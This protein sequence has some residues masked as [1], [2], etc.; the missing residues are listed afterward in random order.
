MKRPLAIFLVTLLAYG[1]TASGH[2]YSPD[3]ELYFR[4]TRSLALGQGLAIE[5]LGGFATRRPAPPRADGKE[6]AQYGIGQPLLAIPFY[7]AG[8]ALGQLG[9]D[10]FWQRLYGTPALDGQALGYAPVS[11][12]LA[13]RW[14]VSWFNI[15]LGAALAALL[16]LVALELVADPFAATWCSVLYAFGTM[17]WP[18]SR[19]FFSEAC[20]TFWTLLAFYGL[21][22]ALRGNRLAWCALAGAAAGFGALTRMDTVFTYPALALVLLGPI[23]S[24]ARMQDR[25]VW[26]EWLAFAAPAALAGAVLLLLNTLHFGGPFQM[27]YSDQPEGVAFRSPLVPGLYGLLLSVGKGLFFFSPVLVLQFWGWG[28]LARQ[29]AGRGKAI[30]WAVAAMIVV[31]LLVHAKWPNWAGGWCWGPRHI[32]LI[33]PFL[34]LPIAALIKLHWGRVVRIAATALLIAGV[35]VQLLGSSQDFIRFYHVFFRAPGSP[36]GFFVLYDEQDQTFWSQYYQLQFRLSEKVSPRAVP[37][38]PPAPI[39]N[40][41]FLPQNSVWAGYPRMFRAGELDNFWVRLLASPTPSPSE[42]LHY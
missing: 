8:A 35:G 25:S 24:R 5:P 30:V 17:A 9:S 27:G 1:L 11:A 42:R 14:A 41:I 33:H 36:N 38:Y 10:A 22:R 6:Y 2:L 4:M 20:A 31:P 7:W 29:T 19:P 39:Q 28:P 40:S 23:W 37:L 21:L 12:E 3:E 18:H 34:A 16:Y 15:V 32:F 13:P 26:P